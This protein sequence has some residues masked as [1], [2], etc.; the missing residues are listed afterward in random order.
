MHYTEEHNIPSLLLLIDFEKAF[1]SVS[2]SFLYKVLEFFGFGNSIISWIKLFNNNASLCVNQSGNLSPFFCIGR[3]CRQGDPVSPFL[4]ILCVEILGIMIRNNKNI[5][6]IYINEKEH[7]LSQYADDTLFLLDGTSKSLN[8]TLNVLSE[9][10]NFSGLKINFDKTHAVW[11][12]QKKYSTA[13][14]KTKWK[15]CWGK[16]E[17]KLLGIMFNVNLDQIL[18]VNYTDKLQKIR[19]L[20]KLWKRRY[21]TPLGKI[22]VI[23]SLLLPILN[24]L[25]IS[26]PNPNDQILKELNNIFFEFLWEGPAKIKQTVVVKQYCEGGLRMINLKAFMNSMKLTWLRR[27][28]TTESPWQYIIKDTINFNEIFSFGTSYIESFLSKIKNKFWIDVMK[29]YS[30]ILKLNKIDNEDSVLSS[31]IFYNYEIKVGN[32]PVWIKNWYKKGV[33]Y[34]ND[35]VRENGHLCSQEEFERMYNAN[36][37]FV[38]YQGIINAVKDFARKYNLLHFTK[39]LKMPFVPINISFLLK[40]KK[41]G[42]DF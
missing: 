4:F 28:T 14:I 7:K 29:A 11:I 17:F 33:I 36:T 20:I 15:L 1:D 5:N 9:F 27:I 18:N 30:E 8:E 10:S 16:T 31:P 34:I 39:K 37:N 23:K 12:G 13:S 32:N 40:S 21:L 19:C 3:G 2:W 22:T 26:I 24:H 25:F 41:G 42:K 38:Q 35:L 6:G